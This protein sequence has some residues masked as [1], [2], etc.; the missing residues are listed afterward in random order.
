MPT[1]SSHSLRRAGIASFTALTLLAA[2]VH[3]AEPARASPEES[4]R[5]EKARDLYTTDQY[6]PSAEIF[7]ELFATTNTAVYLYYAGLAREGAGHEAHAILHW[8]HALKLGLDP[9]FKEKA[10]NRLTQAKTRTTALAATVKPAGLASTATLELTSTSGTRKPITL[11]FAELPVH[12][13]PGNWTATLTTKHPA[14]EPMTLPLVISRGSST[15]AQEFTPKAI[16][17]PTTIEFAPKDAPLER[18]VLV[19]HDTENLVEDLRIPA[20]SNPLIV[21]L[22]RGSWQYTLQAQGQE[23]MTGTIPV[24]ANALPFVITLPTGRNDSEALLPKPTR[25]KLTLGLGLG[26]LAPAIAG[27]TLIGVGMSRQSSAVFSDEQMKLG[28]GDESMQSE[29]TSNTEI[30]YDERKVNT[31]GI[32]SGTGALLLGGAVGL[33]VGAI[34]A[35]RPVKRRTWYGLLGSGLILTTGGLIW[36]IAAYQPRNRDY[37]DTDNFT[38]SPSNWRDYRGHLLGSSSLLGIGAGLGLSSVIALIAAR[39]SS[40]NKVGRAQLA[41]TPHQPGFVLRF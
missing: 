14:F 30:Q 11:A 34:V 36:N 20:T 27:A 29:M 41:G 3:A 9:E 19:L 38:V 24:S 22:R 8:Q 16:E 4:A 25:R 32:F 13:E 17:F 15:L 39:F 5:F 6:L 40:R 12:L 28:P 21:P 35:S 7:E 10:Q 37:E 23:P 2:P 33:S 1:P 18:L 26:A 31:I